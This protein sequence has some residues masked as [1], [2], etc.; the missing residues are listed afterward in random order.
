MQT[1]SFENQPVNFYE[2][3]EEVFSMNP[4]KFMLWLFVVSITMIFA[5]LTSAYIYKQSDKDAWITFDLP[6]VLLYSTIVIVLSSIFMQLSYHFAKKDEI[7][8]LKINLF[9]TAILGVTFL[10]MQWEGWVKLVQMG[11]FVGGVDRMG[12]PVSPAG[13]FVY[14]L[15]GL[16]AFHLITGLIFLLSVTWSAFRFKVHKK[17]MLKIELCNIYWHFLGGLW[18][19]LYLFM[20]LNR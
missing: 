10:V 15:M 7:G 16:H 13:S 12:N 6:E 14:V 3:P 20:S 4:K 18:V 19:Y 9:I 1:T 5:S 17:A 11:I 8:K 2:E